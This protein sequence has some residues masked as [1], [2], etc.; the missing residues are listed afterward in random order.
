MGYK[1][2]NKEIQD[3]NN[4]KIKFIS[5]GCEITKNSLHGIINELKMKCKGMKYETF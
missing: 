5:P 1:I 2:P 3:L 4:A